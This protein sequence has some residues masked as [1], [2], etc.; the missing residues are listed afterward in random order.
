MIHHLRARPASTRRHPAPCR[1]RCTCA[2]TCPVRPALRLEDEVKGDEDGRDQKPGG[3]ILPYGHDTRPR[4]ALRPYA[5]RSERIQT[6]A[7]SPALVTRCVDGASAAEASSSLRQPLPDH[8]PCTDRCRVG[9]AFA[10]VRTPDRTQHHR[11]RRCPRPTCRE[12]FS[13]PFLMRRG[14][15]VSL[16]PHPL[17]DAGAAGLAQDA[18]RHPRSYGLTMSS[19]AD[20]S[21]R[22]LQR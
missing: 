12:P 4:P 20:T 10:R 17:G 13:R 22:H 11:Y 9:P 18:V 15:A 19:Y 14:P 2:V 8:I 16:A 21:A 7:R 3:Q 6:S 1:R 5:V